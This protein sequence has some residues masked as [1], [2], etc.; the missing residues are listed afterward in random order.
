[1]KNNLSRDPIFFGRLVQKWFQ[2]RQHVWLNHY[3]K[4]NM[5]F[6]IYDNVI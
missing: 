1:M 4:D 6:K 3:R 5:E 2:D